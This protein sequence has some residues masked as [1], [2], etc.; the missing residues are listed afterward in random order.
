MAG[1]AH[2][3][4]VGV[5]DIVSCTTTKTLRGPRGGLLLADDAALAKRLNSSVFPGTQGSVHLNVV[6]AKA[7]CFG[8][9]LR[10][11]FA[12]Y[13]ARVVENG[14]AL[15]ATLETRGLPVLTGGTDTH[16]VLVDVSPSGLTGDR[17]EKVIELANLT[18]NKNALPGDPVRPADW[19]GVRLGVAAATTRG[20]STSEMETIGND[21]ADI[22]FTTR[23]DGTPDRATIDRVRADV[24]TIGR[25][26]RTDFAPI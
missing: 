15:A 12:D 1:R 10:P 14:R 24:E 9:A 19:T 13:A 3:S 2:Q 22:W 21:L 20:L 6:A 17:A 25:A 11:D 8:E 16:L 23:P 7:V 5:A 26:S 4:P 18:C